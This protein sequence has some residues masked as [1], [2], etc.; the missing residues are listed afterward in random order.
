LVTF[1]DKNR[2]KPKMITP[3]SY[4]LISIL[5]TIKSFLR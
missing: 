4:M 2:T 3:T 1:F 5:V